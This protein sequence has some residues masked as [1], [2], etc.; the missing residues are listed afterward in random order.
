M[1]NGY[2]CEKYKCGKFKKAFTNEKISMDE[3]YRNCID[4]FE[5]FKLENPINTTI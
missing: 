4:F 2:P 5:K 1:I 3:N